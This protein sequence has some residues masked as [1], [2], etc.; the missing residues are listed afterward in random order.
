MEKHLFV[1]CRK[2]STNMME[3]IKNCCKYFNIIRYKTNK[4]L[5]KIILVLIFLY[6]EFLIIT[7]ILFIYKNQKINQKYFIKN[8]Y[9]YNNSC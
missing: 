1:L 8:D 5:S 9:T 3:T 7:F 2:Y 4:P 6:I